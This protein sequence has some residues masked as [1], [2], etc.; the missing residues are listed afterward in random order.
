MKDVTPPHST[1]QSARR[2]RRHRKAN[3]AK[4]VLQ[5]KVAKLKRKAKHFDESCKI[6]QLTMLD[7]LNGEPTK[8]LQYQLGGG[9]ASL[10]S[11]TDELFEAMKRVSLKEDNEEDNEEGDEAEEEEET[12]EVTENEEK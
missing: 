2:H 11:H 9:L 5:G 6:V 7:F 4:L 10:R 8:M 3:H 12:K 1:R